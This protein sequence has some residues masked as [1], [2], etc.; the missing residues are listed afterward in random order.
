MRSAPGENV[1]QYAT[2]SGIAGVIH[3]GTTGSPNVTCARYNVPLRITTARATS[4]DIP[5]FPIRTGMI[6]RQTAHIS[7]P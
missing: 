4:K 7:R 1:S 2:I 3:P 5:S 6:E